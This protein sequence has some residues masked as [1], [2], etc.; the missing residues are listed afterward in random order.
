MVDLAGTQTTDKGVSHLSGL[1]Q[2]RNLFLWRTHVTDA[3]R[4]NLSGQ[5]PG[6]KIEMGPAPDTSSTPMALRAPKITYA[7]NIFEDTVQV[8]IDFPKMVDVYYT[9]DE[10]SPTTQSAK[11]NREPI[12][13]NKT[14]TIRAISARPGWASSPIVDASFVKRKYKIKE[15]TLQHPPN[16]KYPGNGANSLIDGKIADNFLDKAYLGYEGEHMT[17][18]LDLGETVEVSR[19]SLHCMENNNSW[20]FAPRGLHVWTSGDGKT[21]NKAI[22]RQYPVNTSMQA[23]QV[24]LLSESTPQPVSCRF[25]KVQAESL[26]QNPKWHPGVGKKCWIFVDEILVE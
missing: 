12:V 7:R 1:K 20:I 23:A 10:A 8:L 5:V 25:L 6:L 26:L 21:W 13:L 9:M 19:L 16:P 4:K 15:A 18:V 24:H 3:G 14:T 11:Y 22:D 2:L 17:A